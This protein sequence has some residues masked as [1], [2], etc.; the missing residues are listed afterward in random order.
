MFPCQVRVRAGSPLARSGLELHL[1]QCSLFF[2]PREVAWGKIRVS[3]ESCT[4][5]GCEINRACL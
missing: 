5:N 4:L 1:L 3:L 2:E